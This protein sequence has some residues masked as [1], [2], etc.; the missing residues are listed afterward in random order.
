[1]KMLKQAHT[2]YQTQYHILWVTRYRRKILVNGIDVYIEKI[3]REIGKY[4]PDVSI[5]EIGIDKDHIHLHIIIPPKYAVSN[6]V[7]ALKSNT[8]R[9]LKN[10]FSDF[11]SKVYWDNGGIWATG[12]FVSTVGVNESTIRR[13]VRMQGKHDAGQVVLDL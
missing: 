10:K 8:S 2:V 4:F 5:H 11:L 6:I 3:F 12:F 7:A 1:M 9:I 13:Y